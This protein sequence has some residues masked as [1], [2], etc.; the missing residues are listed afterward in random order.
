MMALP[1]RRVSFAVGI[2]LKAIQH[3]LSGQAEC[4]ALTFLNIVHIDARQGT[5]RVEQRTSGMRRF[6][7]GIVHDEVD[8]VV[9]VLKLEYPPG[10]HP[11]GVTEMLTDGRY[12][13]VHRRKRSREGQLR[14]FRLVGWFQKCK[15]V[16]GVE[17]DY[18]RQL[19]GGRF[20]ADHHRRIVTHYV[21][22][23]YHQ[24]VFRQVHAGAGTEGG[25]NLKYVGA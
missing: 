21:L 15:V 9:F 13:F 2:I 10:T 8:T 7:P 4:A 16:V 17:V 23:G 1:W 12:R 25:G 18:L 14:E 20:A 5:R 19:L 11:E 6:L 24:A 22:V 3:D